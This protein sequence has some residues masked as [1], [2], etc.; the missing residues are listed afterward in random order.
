MDKDSF[1]LAISGDSLDDIVTPE[2]KKAYET[3]KEDRLVIDQFSKR[4]PGLFRPEFVK[5]YSEVPPCS[6]WGQ[7]K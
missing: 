1:Y 4:T 5:C 3:Y 7:W 6:K 2:I